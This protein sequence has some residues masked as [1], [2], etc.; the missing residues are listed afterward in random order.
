MLAVVLLTQQLEGNFL[1]PV[2]LGRTTA[3]HPLVTM[4]AVVAGGAFGGVIGM[5]LAVPLAAGAIATVR[6][7]RRAGWPD[8]RPTPGG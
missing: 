7:L 3:L 1:Q 2:V 8:S 4:L 6:A 5:L